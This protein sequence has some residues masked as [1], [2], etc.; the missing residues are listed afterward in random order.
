MSLPLVHRDA[1]LL[2]VENRI[3]IPSKAC[4][5]GEQECPVLP[6]SMAGALP[7][8]TAGIKLPYTSCLRSHKSCL[9]KKTHSFHPCP[10]QPHYGA[11]NSKSCPY[12]SRCWQNA[13]G[14]NTGASNSQDVNAS[15]T[16]LW[17]L[18]WE[19]FF[20]HR[21]FDVAWPG[22][23]AREAEMIQGTASE[24][25]GRGCTGN[26]PEGVSLDLTTPH[27]LAGPALLQPGQQVGKNFSQ[28]FSQ[29][30]AVGHISLGSVAVP[31]HRVCSPEGHCPSL[32]SVAVPAVWQCQLSGPALLQAGRGTAA[33]WHVGHRAPLC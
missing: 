15:R 27:S 9:E 16:H 23:R 31:T 8:L 14:A 7:Q 12:A 13:E 20:P 25:P 3:N 30:R 6:A 29:A 32:G 33:G 11:A 24:G 28:I 4:T 21:T 10:V 18:H 1:E 5:T 19:P 22:C 17:R 2:T 26:V